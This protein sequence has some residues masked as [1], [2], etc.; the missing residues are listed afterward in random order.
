MS[1][2]LRTPLNAV[3]GLAKIG[4][5]GVTA[6]TAEEKIRETFRLISNSGQHLLRLVDDILDFSKIEQVS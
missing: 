4:E 5:R 6:D 2:E 3:L 1:H